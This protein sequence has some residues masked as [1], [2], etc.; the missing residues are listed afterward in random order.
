MGS[1]TFASTLGL[2]EL[3]A[4]PAPQPPEPEPTPTPT[5]TPV[6]EPMCTA[7]AQSSSDGF[8]FVISC[9]VEIASFTISPPSGRNF[10]FVSDPP[11]YTCSVDS[12][13]ISCD[14]DAD[15]D[16]QVS[17]FAGYSDPQG[18]QPGEVFQ[19]TVNGD[20]DLEVTAT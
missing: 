1:V 15:G 12:G 11:G 8:Q 19:I 2:I 13:V 10:L 17:L 9:D 5:P 20:I 16:L 14:A 3:E 18:H 4:A 6:P 7:T